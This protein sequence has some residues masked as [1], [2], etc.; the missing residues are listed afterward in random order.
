MRFWAK[1]NLKGEKNA[2][3]L[4]RAFFKEFNPDSSIVIKGKEAIIEVVFDEPPKE[5]VDA[6]SHCEVIEFSY[7]KKMQESYGEK[8]E[9]PVHVAI[10]E[11][12][13]VDLEEKPE[14]LERAEEPK[15]EK[16]L[17]EEGQQG[18]KEDQKAKP[19]RYQKK[20]VFVDIKV[21]EL[22][23]F[24]GKATSFENFAELTAQ[25]L[26]MGKSQEFFKE[27]VIAFSE[28]EENSVSG[29]EEILKNKNVHYT[30]WTKIF[31]S[32]QISKKLK[33]KYAITMAKLLYIMKQYKDYKFTNVQLEM[34]SEVEEGEIEETPAEEVAVAEENSGDE[35]ATIVEDEQVES[36]GVFQKDRVK[37]E[38]MPVIT[39]FEEKLASIDMTQSIE[40]RVSYVLELMGLKKKSSDAQ[41]KIFEIANTAVRLAKIS[42]DSI[43][44]MVKIPPQAAMEARIIFSEFINDFAKKYNSENKIK[45]LDF[46]K[47][48]Q[49]V[50]MFE[51]EIDGYTDFD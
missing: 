4:I 50:V 2:E 36:K 46:L 7:G 3:Y 14:E 13:T 15:V 43:F 5:I 41:Q 1:V 21:P 39:D 48:L 31:C 45:L 35:D 11:N 20:V 29:A 44:V 22:D 51:S 9:G 37:M 25:W 23:E 19:G 16:E 12:V 27:L 30:E 17:S 8:T 34:P 33:E 28:V 49:K 24:A 18:V 32:K 26:E 10:E 6:I 42:L 40:D 38:C 47:D